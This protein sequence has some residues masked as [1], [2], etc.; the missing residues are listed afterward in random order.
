[1]DSITNSKQDEQPLIADKKLLTPNRR[2][3]LKE[4]T[5]LAALGGQNHP[6]LITLLASYQKK[7][8]YHLIFPCA[9]SNLRVFWRNNAM[10]NFDRETVLWSIKQMLGTADGLYQIHA[11][12][13]QY[14]LD[15]QSNPLTLGIGRRLMVRAGEEKY[16]RHGDIKAE[17]LL[18]FK[19]ENVLKITDFGLGR[20]HGRDSQSGI[21]PRK[22]VGTLTY[23]PP[24]CAI[25]KSVSRAYDIWSMGCLYLEF[26]TWLMEGNDKIDEFSNA[27]VKPGAYTEVSDDNFF[28]VINKYQ[29][30]K[31]REGVVQWVD[32]LHAHK[33]CSQLIHDLLDFIMEHMLKV[34]P[35]ERIEAKGLKE[36]MEKLVAS[37]ESSDEYL[38]G[39][40]PRF[41]DTS[42]EASDFSIDRNSIF[43]IDAATQSSKTSMGDAQLLNIAADDLA[44]LL[45][46]DHQL[47]SLCLAAIGVSE[48]SEERFKRNFRRLLEIYSVDLKKEAQTREQ[49]LAVTLARSR[50][51]YVSNRICQ[52]ASPHTGNFNV[53]AKLKREPVIEEFLRGLAN[54]PEKNSQQDEEV[55]PTEE[56][57]VEPESEDD[58][59]SDTESEDNFNIGRQE[60]ESLTEFVKHFIIS[61]TAFE[62]LRRNLRNFVH[63]SFKIMLDD[64]VNKLSYPKNEKLRTISR[65]N[66]C[67]LVYELQ[68]VQPNEIK[69]SYNER[70]N[71][72]NYIK[73]MVEDRTGEEWEWWPFKPRRR[74]IL[75][76]EAR[77]EWRC[78][79]LDSP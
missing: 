65:Y 39:A 44:E 25:G 56:S 42:S 35:A 20:F 1:M 43:S 9:D 63:P 24:E 64:L 73:G 8:C 19:E 78:V 68:D 57:K 67:S 55:L 54:A 75:P 58:N 45:F 61:S 2:E 28:T 13:V 52:M 30:V 41:P 12:K 10:P 23:E 69:I 14:D 33:N 27:R 51:R 17:N 4:K 46:T 50:S 77:L 34:D 21:D 37:A 74:V 47:K 32:G 18:W 60:P 59:E 31:V 5:I 15:V 3:F 11:F 79:S 66:L 71:L 7:K 38:I 70:F 53:L 76:G 22:V 16:G 62:S 49:F 26:I 6:H 48:I 36:K 72:F 29:E 40:N